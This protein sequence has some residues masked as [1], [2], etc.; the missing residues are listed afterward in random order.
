MSSATSA[1]QGKTE[2]F[3]TAAASFNLGGQTVDVLDLKTLLITRG[4]NVPEEI[5]DWTLFPFRIYGH[6]NSR[7][8]DSP[9]ISATRAT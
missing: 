2:Q 7:W 1:W 5:R 9:A 3:G 6:A 8:E 4:I